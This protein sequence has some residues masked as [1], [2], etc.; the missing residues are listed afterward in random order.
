MLQFHFILA[1]FIIKSVQVSFRKANDMTNLKVSGTR[2]QGQDDFKAQYHVFLLYR[3]KK[4]GDKN[5]C[6]LISSVWALIPL[7]LGMHTCTHAQK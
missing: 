7:P 3:R 5:Y 4:L 6:N 1:A 2:C